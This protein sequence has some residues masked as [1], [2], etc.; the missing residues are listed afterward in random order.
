[1][2][3]FVRIGAIPE[4]I[5]GV[6]A[7]GYQTFRRGTNVV[8]IWGGVTVTSGRR[9][10]WSRTPKRITHPKRTIEAARRFLAQVVADRTNNKYSLLPRGTRIGTLKKP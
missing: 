7:R 5:S 8:V 3:Y 2:A 6:G 4:N 10:Y 1:M 9:F